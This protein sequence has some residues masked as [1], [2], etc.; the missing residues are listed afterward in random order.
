[1]NNSVI[2]G[3][4]NCYP[5]EIKLIDNKV[6]I[7]CEMSLGELKSDNLIV[8]IDKIGHPLLVLNKEYKIERNSEAINSVYHIAHNFKQYKFLLKINS[9]WY[10]KS[11]D[12][13]KFKNM[14][15]S[16]LVFES[17]I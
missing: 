1:M 12:I 7:P 15:D 4:M 9:D 13:D 11:I 6:I 16:V 2:L 8:L 3:Q 5:E 10:N 17:N 14:L